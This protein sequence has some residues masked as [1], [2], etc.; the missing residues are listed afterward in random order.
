MDLLF[1]KVVTIS[2]HFVVCRGKPQPPFEL[3]KPALPTLA[4]LIYSSDEE[5]FSLSPDHGKAAA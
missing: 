2:E 5:V 4:G 1:A 3:V